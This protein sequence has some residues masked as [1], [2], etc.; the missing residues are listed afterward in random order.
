MLFDAEIKDETVYIKR[1]VGEFLGG[2][3][4]EQR[5]TGLVIL[6]YLM[7][8]VGEHKNA[9]GIS[10]QDISEGKLGIDE[11]I[12]TIAKLYLNENIWKEVSRRFRIY[13]NDV[14][15]KVA[16][17]TMDASA[18][19]LIAELSVK[20]LD[21][22]DGESIFNWGCGKGDFLLAA[23]EKRPDA[24]YEGCE[25]DL[26][27]YVIAKVRAELSGDNIKITR[28]NAIDC[29]RQ[30]DKVLIGGAMSRERRWGRERGNDGVSDLEFY[31]MIRDAL[32]SEGKALIAIER[33]GYIGS[34][35]NDF[36]KRIIE[37]KFLEC[38]IE[39][40]RYALNAPTALVLLSRGNDKTKMLD[41]SRI[42][43]MRFARLRLSDEMVEREVETI[44][45][46]LGKDGEKNCKAVSLAEMREN[47]YDLNVNV[48]LKEKIEFDGGVPFG[49]VIK[50]ITRGA[51]IPAKELEMKKTSLATNTRYLELGA[52][53][54]DGSLEEPLPCLSELDFKYDRY[55]AKNNDLLIAKTGAIG[56]VAV[57]KL[58]EG[59][60]LFVGGNFYIIELDEEKV[61]PYFLKA[62]FES[63]RGREALKSIAVG[64]AL[65]S[66]KI[67][68]LKEMQIPLP[69]ME[70]QKKMAKECWEALRMIAYAK[71]RLNKEVQRLRTIFN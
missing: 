65:P 69:P 49:S 45:D 2:R 47:E 59:E 9:D 63:A 1:L 56:K 20:L 71:S 28:S 21:L 55:C 58:E 36:W 67:G 24:I 30:F 48:Y 8:K 43:G 52:I 35:N 42:A 11:E 6:S 15:A 26:E 70:E 13:R 17:A 50:N 39:L 12:L 7:Y 31:D 25:N 14:W 46:S 27:K 34:R 54:Q 44:L 53:L 10:W 33:W 38:V 32:G 60:R 40:P 5:E 66:I 61:E 37:R 51:L 16:L 41:A 18:E 4:F 64:Q 68:D 22:K 57:A 29:S 19:R 62:F 23:R 3:T